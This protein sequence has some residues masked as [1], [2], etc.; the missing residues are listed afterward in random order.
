MSQQPEVKYLTTQQVAKRFSVS[1]RTVWRW[2]ESGL[3]APPIGIGD[4]RTRRWPVAEIEQF[5]RRMLAGRQRA[6]A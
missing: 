1:T 5:E 6:G 3:L 2:A 4:Q